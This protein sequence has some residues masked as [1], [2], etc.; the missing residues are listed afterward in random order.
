MPKIGLMMEGG[1][2]KCA[3]GAG[4]TDAFLE[5][6]VTFDYVIGV[7][8][9]S[10]NGASF[11][12]GQHGRNRRFYTDHI[13]EPEYF[14]VRNLIKCGDMFNLNYIY[15]TLSNEGGA[16]HL[17]FDAFMANPAQYECVATNALTGKPHYFSKENFQRNHYVEIM[18]S[19]AI[20]AICR[21][22]VIDGVPYYDGG[23]SDALP[24]ERAFKMGCDKV[25]CILSKARDYVRGPQKFRPAYALLCRKYP[26]TV[27][28]IDKRY[29]NYTKQQQ[30]MYELEKAGKLFIFS[31]DTDIEIGTYTMKPELNDRIYHLGLEDFE[32]KKDD[33]KQ[34]MTSCP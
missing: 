27:Q 19:S 6:N 18:A 25:V 8:A 5:N 34:F 20:P 21:P 13:T 14:G 26:K 7:S 28:A 29:L 10:A 16:D 15:A 24:Y 33:L 32:K 12:A 4:V 2:M 1:G 11:L 31:V 3:Y 17:D 9:G 22:V 30:K 23:I